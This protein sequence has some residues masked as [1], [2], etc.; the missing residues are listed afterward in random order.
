MSSDQ[1]AWVALSIQPR[2]GLR[3]I[4]ALQAHFQAD[5]Y[6][7]LQASASELQRIPGIGQK[8][9]A[10]IQSIDLNRVA[11][12]VA[13]W[14]A[15]DISIVCYGTAGYPQS[16]QTIEFPPAT[17]FIRGNWPPALLQRTAAIVGTRQ[18][19]AI[20]QQASK[21]LVAHL[22]GR[23]YSI[24][25]GLAY[26]VDALAHQSACTQQ[27]HTLAVLGCG[28]LNIYP[29]EHHTL[30]E[31]ISGTGGAL[32]SEAAPD[33]TVSTPLLV[34]RNRIIS[35]LS[36]HVFII[37]T[38]S[39]GGAMHAARHAQKQGRTLYALDL[40]HASGNQALLQQGAAIPI[41]PDLDDL[42]QI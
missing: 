32:L 15:A 24:I 33:A 21:K 3:I 12:R 27:G 6:A 36:Q 11:H 42:P 26:G 38:S 7:A 40:P 25:S 13:H 14:Q 2:I 35:G 34:S 39:D 1:L 30:A 28:V 22:T 29:P 17:L 37:E 19:S 41:K 18:P 8:T 9:A 4:Q 23:G 10:H 5:L 31:Q 20:A 16:L